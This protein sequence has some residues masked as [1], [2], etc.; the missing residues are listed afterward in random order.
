IADLPLLYPFVVNDPG[1]GTQ[2]KRRAHAVV[3]DHLIPP[4]STADAYGPI[5]AV[6]QLMDEYFQAQALDPDR[7]PLIQER[8]WEEVRRAHLDADL[9]QPSVPD[10]F[11]AFLLRMDGYLCEIKDAQIRNGLHVLGAPPE[12]EALLDMVLAGAGAAADVGR[13]LQP[14]PRAAWW[15]RP[16]GAERSADPGDDPR[17][18]HRAQLLLCGPEGAA[19][20]DVLAGRTAARRGRRRAPRRRDRGTA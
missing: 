9:A 14:P 13:D 12:G 11:D 8:I 4:V 7:L 3:V 19:D 16:G 17:A 2:A 18:P 6:E 10:D 20:G 1:E 5:V 15:I